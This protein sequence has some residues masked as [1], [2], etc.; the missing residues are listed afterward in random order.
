[1]IVNPKNTEKILKK[2]FQEGS[3]MI[4]KLRSYQTSHKKL[5]TDLGD[6]GTE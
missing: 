2:S 4:E 3:S 1:M 5:I 6:Y